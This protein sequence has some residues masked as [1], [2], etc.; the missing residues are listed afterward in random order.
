[1]GKK[2]VEK[3]EI[4]R[5]PSGAAFFWRRLEGRPLEVY[6]QSRMGA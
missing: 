1:M 6:E 4:H 3:Q 5:S 2:A